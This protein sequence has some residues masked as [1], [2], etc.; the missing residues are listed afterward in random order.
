VRLRA[1]RSETRNRRAPTSESGWSSRQTGLVN[2]R[3][4][5]IVDVRFCMGICYSN[6]RGN[7]DGTGRCSPTFLSS[8]RFCIVIGLNGKGRRELRPSG[9]PLGCKGGGKSPKEGRVRWSDESTG[10]RSRLGKHPEIA[11]LNTVR[12]LGECRE[13]AGGRD[14]PWATLRDVFGLN[15]PRSRTPLGVTR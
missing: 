1:E 13:K 8:C 14:F 4:P 6:S 9:K 15:N 5:D 2:R 3:Y 7:P 11:A 10:G 12:A